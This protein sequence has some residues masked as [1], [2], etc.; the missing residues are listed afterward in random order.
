MS[1][2]QYFKRKNCALPDPD[3][4]LAAD[5]P[6]QIIIA[7]N[8]QVRT[9]QD[10][11]SKRGPYRITA[12][13]TER[14]K[15]GKYAS[16]HGVAATLRHFKGLGL[17]DSTVRDWKKLYEKEYREKCREAKALAKAGE[18]EAVPE[19]T[20]LPSKKR[21]RPPLLGEKL[22]MYLRRYIIAM[23]SRGTPVGSSIVVGVA[24][25]ILLRHSKPTLEDIKLNLTQGWAKQVLRRMG[26]TKRRANS[27][28]KIT[29][30][31]FEE[32]KRLFLIEIKSVVVMEEIPPELVIN[33]DHTA[34]KIVP[35]SNW[36]MEKKGTKRV[37]IAAVDDKRQITAV[38]ACT[39][40][41]I[42]LPVQLI[43]E[44]KTEKCHPSIS[45]PSSWHIT[46]TDN[47]W[48]NESTTLEYLR[49]II[50]P[51]VE[52][53]RSELKLDSSYPALVIFDVF[54]GQCTTAVLQMLKDHHILYVTIPNNCTDR[55]QPLD[56]SVNKAVKQFMRS[57]FQ[58]W[59]GREICEQLE[60]GVEEEVDLRLTIM[61]PLSA[62]WM[63]KCYQYLTNHSH[64]AI[65][66][67][68]AAGIAKAC[69]Y[70]ST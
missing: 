10:K 34:M 39:L 7:A 12:D 24:R 33:W 43:Y 5:V 29:P 3:G 55:L 21:G 40:T 59:Y 69:N 63:V 23:R 8:N 56:M 61:K 57:E 48:A 14:A 15:I 19:V 13:A 28:A 37:E 53:T 26:F 51:Y 38:L 49:L 36:T 60:R 70:H 65:N 16:F 46:H 67:F 68:R 31:N 64:L 18:D 1:L 30:Q 41:G 32:I 2:L 47:H 50:I 35:S 66:G 45:F 20:E 6:P 11:E 9:T 54:K 58:D 22:D 25:G 62:Q 27:K 42:F 52:K 4:G 17:K 44:R